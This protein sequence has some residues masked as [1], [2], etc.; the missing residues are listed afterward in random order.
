VLWAP[1]NANLGLPTASHMD[2]R[3]IGFCVG[4]PR[5]HVRG[6]RFP[7]GLGWVG[8]G[9]VGLGWGL[10]SCGIIGAEGGEWRNHNRE[11]SYTVSFVILMNCK[12]EEGVND[13]AIYREC[14][15]PLRLVAL[16]SL[17]VTLEERGQQ[18]K[19]IAFIECTCDWKVTHGSHSRIPGF[20]KR[21]SQSRR[22]A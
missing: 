14:K 12:H 9:W 13:W 22:A 7:V 1:R 19:Q 15:Q 20:P 4:V 3:D 8:L 11:I 16:L 10:A 17:Q 6:P 5:P 21:S 2:F 18:G